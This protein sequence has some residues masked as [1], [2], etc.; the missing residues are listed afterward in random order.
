MWA[1]QEEKGTQ[2]L[3][4]R[5]TELKAIQ[6]DPPSSFMTPFYRL[7]PGM[8]T[9]YQGSWAQHSPLSLPDCTHM[10]RAASS[11][12]HHGFFDVMDC[13][14]RNQ[15][16]SLLFVSGIVSQPWEKQPNSIGNLVNWCIHY[17][18]CCSNKICWQNQFNW[19]SLCLGSL[20][21][22]TVHQGGTVCYGS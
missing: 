22:G 14:T 13:Q 5:Q 3:G 21:K 19:K 7:G 12:C 2:K 8:N 20:I 4:L 15:N 18:S 1:E 6:K 11:S 9:K 17:F 16:E 10:Q